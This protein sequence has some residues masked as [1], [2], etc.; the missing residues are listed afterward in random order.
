M[1]CVLRS[2]LITPFMHLGDSES[3]SMQRAESSNLSV[4]DATSE[5]FHNF[6]VDIKFIAVADCVANQIFSQVLYQRI[7]RTKR[8]LVSR[9]LSASCI[10]SSGVT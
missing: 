8:T 4:S 7:T 5:S 1:G 2:E 10:L 3:Q 6:I 9:V